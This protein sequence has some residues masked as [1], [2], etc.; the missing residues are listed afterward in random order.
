M[1]VDDESVIIGSANI[2]DRSMLG[3]R[4]S[5]FC[6]LIN[7]TMKFDSIMDGNAYK[8][9][10]FAVTLRKALM[11]EHLGVDADDERLIDP[12]SDEL[13]KL[14]MNTAKKIL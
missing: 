4:D 10:K 6:V 3:S 14:F 11:S 2:N 12:V 9:A 8:S 5:E 1:I 13:L 7:E